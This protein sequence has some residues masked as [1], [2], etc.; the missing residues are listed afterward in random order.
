MAISTRAGIE[1][2]D[3]DEP[4]SCAERDHCWW[5]RV[6]CALENHHSLQWL[7]KIPTE[8]LL[9]KEWSSKGKVLNFSSVI[10]N[11]NS[12]VV[13]EE[14]MYKLQVMM[15]S[16]P[17]L[18]LS[19]LFQ[20]FLQR[21]PVTQRILCK[22]IPN[23]WSIRDLFLTEQG[24][25]FFH[26]STNFFFSELEIFFLQHLPELNWIVFHDKNRN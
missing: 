7:H 12:S 5:L 17:R 21:R 15:A 9:N 24:I 8:N 4:A 19:S 1:A 26:S 23:S 14:R 22:L 2:M 6:R 18:W 11:N 20:V 16:Q 10:L 25:D 13:Y 3:E